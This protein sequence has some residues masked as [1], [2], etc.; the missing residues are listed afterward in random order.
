[1]GPGIQIEGSGSRHNLVQNNFIGTNAAG[2]KSLVAP[3]NGIQTGDDGIVI[4]VAPLNQ[5]GGTTRAERNL[6]SGNLESG[7]AVLGSHSTG[8]VVEGNFIGS[9][10]TGTKAISNCASRCLFGRRCR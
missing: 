9:D 1:M 4:V 6:I 7:I 2:T 3:K 5:I 8:N 10:T